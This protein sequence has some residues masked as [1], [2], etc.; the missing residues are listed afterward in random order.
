[1]LNCLLSDD[2]KELL[3]EHYGLDPHQYVLL[4]KN[5]ETKVFQDIKKRERPISI[6]W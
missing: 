2:D 4:E 6:R 3:N 5:A 1:M